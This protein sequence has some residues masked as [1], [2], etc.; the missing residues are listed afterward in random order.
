ILDVPSNGS[1]ESVPRHRKETR[2]AIR[3]VKVSLEVPEGV[4][5]D[6][7][8]TAQTQAEEAA[9]LALWQAGNLSTRRAAEEL[10]VTY[11][12]VLDLL[13]AKGIPVVRGPLDEQALEE[14]RRKLARTQP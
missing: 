10:E 4:S 13:A 9:V 1:R 14:A 11:R 5:E 6:V 3:T 7:R 12:E 2:M 8:Q